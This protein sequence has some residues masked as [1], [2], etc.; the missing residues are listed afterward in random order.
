MA[1]GLFFWARHQAKTARGRL[2]I[3]RWKLKIPLFGKIFLFS[4]VSRFC[5]VLGTLL[6]NGVP[7]L[8]ALEISSDSTG[9]KILAGAIRKSGENISSGQTLARP[10][11]DCGLLPR[12]VIAM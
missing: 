7:L 12:P 8:R 4:A 6:K 3:D 1:A 5:R 11:A 9:N 10:L 2:L